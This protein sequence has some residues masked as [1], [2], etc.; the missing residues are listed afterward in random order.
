M[1]H[2]PED[3]GVESRS[4]L[5]WDCSQKLPTGNPIAESPTFSPRRRRR[6]GQTRQRTGNLLLRTDKTDGRVSRNRLHAT[7][8]IALR[9]VQHREVAWETPSRVVSKHKVPL[10]ALPAK[11]G[12]NE[13]LA[14]RLS[15][16]ALERDYVLYARNKSI[17]KA[18]N[19]CV[20]T[21]SLT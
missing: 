1:P 16:V 7:G 10:A 4:H 8:R 14:G 11:G 2:G 5:A 17:D 12:S 15:V 19:F 13:T 21:V 20:A 6:R 18:I 3:L 9:Y